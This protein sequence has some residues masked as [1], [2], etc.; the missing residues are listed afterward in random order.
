[1]PGKNK[2]RLIYDSKF[3][4]PEGH[5][6]VPNNKGIFILDDLNLN[7]RQIIYLGLN[8]DP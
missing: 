6:R 2:G 8:R 4:G 7:T 5:I 1:M 3:I